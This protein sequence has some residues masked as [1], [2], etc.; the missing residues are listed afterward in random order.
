[1]PKRKISYM[2]F[3]TAFLLILSAGNIP[4]ARAAVSEAQ[5]LRILIG[6]AS[7]EGERGMQAVGEVLRRRNSTRGFYGLNAPHVDKQPAWVWDM[8]R[9]A[10]MKSA[11]SNI[12]KDAD[13]FEGTSFK[14]PKWARGLTP[15]ITIGKQKFYRLKGR[16]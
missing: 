9:R 7:G 15:T 11:A 12:T 4:A 13:H 14:T 8:A 16:V 6:E 10:W 2:V 1:M 5:A 3:T